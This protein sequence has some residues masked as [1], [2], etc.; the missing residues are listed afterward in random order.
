MQSLVDMGSGEETKLRRAIY[1]LSGL[2]ILMSNLEILTSKMSLFSLE[3]VFSQ[4]KLIAA[5]RLL[6]FVAIALFFLRILET[7]PNCI[8]KILR[9]KDQ[10]WW[11][12]ISKQIDEIHL[13]EKRHREGDWDDGR[14][15][16]WDDEAYIELGVRKDKRKKVL[17]YYRPIATL[18]RFLVKRI[19]PLLAA[20]IA[21][22]Y[23]EF[24]FALYSP[25]GLPGD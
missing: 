5:T 23:P 17:S 14:P 25:T 22:F 2:L 10:R 15:Y 24:L 18:N 19:S 7:I 16:D 8:A 6:L 4:P 11:K 3:F 9:W 20:T 1:V 21:L 13:A 12:P